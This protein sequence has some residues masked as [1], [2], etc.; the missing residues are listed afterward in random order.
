[1]SGSS[2]S[3]KGDIPFGYVSGGSSGPPV[4]VAE[5]TE[6]LRGAYERYAVGDASLMDIASYLN[7]QG[8]AP[9]SK[10][11]SPLREHPRAGETSEATRRASGA[12][13]DGACW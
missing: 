12:V 9:R 8:L 6:A 2:R 3:S 7:A 5:E 10:R 4:V 13:E 1:M 11:G